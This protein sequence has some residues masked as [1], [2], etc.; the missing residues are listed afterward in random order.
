MPPSEQQLREEIICAGRMM[1][2]RG[3]IAANDGN[4]TARLDRDRILATPA[5]VCKGRMSPEDILVC[6]NEGNRICG[7]RPRTT[8][9]AMHVAI[10]SARPDIQAVVH[11]HPPTSTGFAVAGRALNLGLMP[12][13]IVSM[14][15]VP[16]ADYGLPGTPALVEGMLPYIPKF[17]AIL[18]ANHGAVCYG[19]SVPQAYSRLE[20]LEHLARITLVAEL[21]GGAKVLPRVEVEKLFDARSRYGISVPNQF[22]P[23]NPMVAED[24]P[25]ASDKDD[26]LE[27]TR[28]QLLAVIEE[29][30]RVRGLV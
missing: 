12:E 9:M 11:A 3:W 19:E 15:S 6:D 13:L 30:L 21:L 27:F 23:G 5:G 4:I 22:E 20:T 10:Y 16:L 29:A 28:Q 25:D 24:M 18:L 2:E 1:Y 17:N 26:K 7:D 14:G 8:E